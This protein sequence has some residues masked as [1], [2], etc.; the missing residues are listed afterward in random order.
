MK[1]LL[2][3]VVA[4]IVIAGVLN[5]AFP[6][7]MTTYGGM[8]LNYLKSLNAPP[9]TLST[10]SNP[11]Y[12]APVAAVPSPPLA[13]AAWPNAA[14]GDWPSYN[15]TPTSQRYS[16]LTQINTK[17]VANLKVLCTYDVREVTA[18][19]SGLLVVDNALIGTTEHYIFSI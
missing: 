14:E 10:E 13:E 18:F 9:G 2:I 16:P 1:K 7:P 3:A 8:G 12:Q 19:E 5:V 6:V 17:N 11:A 4:L 15:R